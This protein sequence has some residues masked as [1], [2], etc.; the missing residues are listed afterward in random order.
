M[1]CWH[2]YWRCVWT[3]DRSRLSR[4]YKKLG[5]C[6]EDKKQQL[7]RKAYADSFLQGQNWM[8]AQWGRRVDIMN[9][10]SDQDCDRYP[11][12]VLGIG[13]CIYEVSARFPFSPPHA[14]VWKLLEGSWVITAFSNTFDN[15]EVDTKQRVTENWAMCFDCVLEQE[16]REKI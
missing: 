16:I 7:G 1:L 11:I 3:E 2:Q 5:Y 13:T 6:L 9:A 14:P 10:C 4:I 15:L 12:C 8:K